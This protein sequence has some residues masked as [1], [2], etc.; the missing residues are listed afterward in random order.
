MKLII[1][2]F[3]TLLLGMGDPTFLPAPRQPGLIPE[4]QSTTSNLNQIHRDP[5]EIKPVPK[6]QEEE[7]VYQL[8][9]QQQ[10]ME[11]HPL[12]SEKIK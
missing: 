8:E 7:R 11:P 10:R 9:S 3:S 2:L 12:P 1:I 4:I 6:Q 5:A